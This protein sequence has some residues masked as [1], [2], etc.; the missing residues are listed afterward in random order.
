MW[1]CLH[2]LKTYTL[3]LDGRLSAVERQSIRRRL[4]TRRGVLGARFDAASPNRLRVDY[5]ADLVG[6]LGLLDALRLDGIAARPAS[7]AV[8]PAAQIAS[9]AAR[10]PNP[11]RPHHMQRDGNVGKAHARTLE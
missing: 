6:P 2:N 4:L 7:A 10:A 11:S 5:N 3:D 9:V 1:S 8:P